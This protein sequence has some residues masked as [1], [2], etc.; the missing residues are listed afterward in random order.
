MKKC[1]CYYLVNGEICCTDGYLYTDKNKELWYVYKLSNKTSTS[2]FATNRYSGQLVVSRNRKKDVINYLNDYSDLLRFYTS[3]NP[4]TLSSH[5]NFMS[6]VS[7]FIIDNL[8][9]PMYE[10]YSREGI[11]KLTPTQISQILEYF[12][13]LLDEFREG[14]NDSRSDEKSDN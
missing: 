11:I 4:G 10:Y 7:D 5:C 1:K 6:K 12:D 14:I 9:I 13:T 2:W 8:K 3:K